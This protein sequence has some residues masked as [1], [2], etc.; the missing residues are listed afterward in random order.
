MNVELVSLT[1]IG[2][3]IFMHNQMQSELD[4]QVPKDERNDMF[5]K[6]DSQ[7]NINDSS[8]SK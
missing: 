2:I 7:G 4:D 8:K 1:L 6:S 5:L 3:D